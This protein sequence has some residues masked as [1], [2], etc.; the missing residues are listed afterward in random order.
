MSGNQS[1]IV[2]IV[3]VVAAAA[4]DVDSIGAACRGSRSIVITIAIGGRREA[5]DDTRRHL[6]DPHRS[7]L[8]AIRLTSALRIR[9]QTQNEKCCCCDLLCSITKFDS[10]CRMNR[11]TTTHK[12]IVFYNGKPAF[13][14]QKPYII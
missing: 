7:V 14:I 8:F 9:H 2:N 6:V 10:I 4:I 3:I 1:H 11:Q 5:R 12:K 13:S